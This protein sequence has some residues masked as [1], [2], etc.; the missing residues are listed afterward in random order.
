[1]NI[2]QAYHR[3]LHLPRHLL[4]T[5]GWYSD[6]WWREDEP[7]LTCT[8]EEREKVLANSLVVS[9]EIFLD[10]ERDAD[11][12]TATGI[13][14]SKA[15]LLKVTRSMHAHWINLGAAGGEVTM[16]EMF[17]NRDSDCQSQTI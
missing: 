7:G 8:V 4:V 2:L 17:A 1:M 15:K 12:I 6:F 16:G 10:I 11:V 14:R 9:D 5:I 3:G 13:V